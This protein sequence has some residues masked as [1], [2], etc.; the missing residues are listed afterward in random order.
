[1][2]AAGVYSAVTYN[3]SQREKE[4]GIRIAMGATPLHIAF[5]VCRHY[6]TLGAIGGLMGTLVGGASVRLFSKGL[7]L[8]EVDSFD[9][10]VF[11]SAFAICVF[12]VLASVV[13]P[14]LRATRVSPAALLLRDVA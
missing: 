12:V 13:A 4:L 3:L 9:V 2:A 14:A 10:S 7:S 11:A 5:A 1:M 6:A 8:F